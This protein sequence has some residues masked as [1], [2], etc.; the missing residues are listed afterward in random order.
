[1]L[2]SP[3]QMQLRGVLHPQ[4]HECADGRE[5]GRTLRWGAESLH[6][7]PRAEGAMSV[8]ETSPVR[9][10]AQQTRNV[11]HVETSTHCSRKDV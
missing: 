11:A 7:P 4:Q 10:Q 1:M 2:E 9:E 8:A 3:I 5:R 6:D